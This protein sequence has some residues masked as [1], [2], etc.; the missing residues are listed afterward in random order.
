MICPAYTSPAGTLADGKGKGRKALLQ[1]KGT[2]THAGRA[3]GISVIADF[4]KL[5]RSDKEDLDTQAKGST[6]QED[7]TILNTCLMIV[8]VA[9]L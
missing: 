4:L 5:I 8:N 7:T 6:H 9:T 1:A 2:P 3:I